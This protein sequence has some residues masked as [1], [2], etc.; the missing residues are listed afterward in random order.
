[1]RLIDTIAN[2]FGFERRNIDPSW[3]AVSSGAGALATINGRAAENI[4][5]VYACTSAISSA[6]AYIPA[7]VYRR[8][9]SGNR[10]EAENHALT[11]LTRHGVNTQ[12]TWPEL[13][14]HLVAS[15]L[16]NGNGLAEVKYNGRGQIAGLEFI[17]WSRVSV[18]YLSS[19]KLAY[20][21]SDLRGNGAVRRLLEGEVL[22]LRDRTDDGLIGRSRLSRA[23]D[24][25]ERGLP[26]WGFVARRC[27]R[28]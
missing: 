2:H 6:L 7:L 12:M 28:P 20:N 26:D 9:T 16:L 10:I 5:A 18:E 23:R 27:D 21:V 15:T 14:E 25:V 3:S 24:S 8:D 11:K 17:P 1:M 22:H 4:S 13:I 19:G